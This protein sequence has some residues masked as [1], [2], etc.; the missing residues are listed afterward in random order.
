M[1]DSERKTAIAVTLAVLAL[2]VCCGLHLLVG[3]G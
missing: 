1:P 2:A 3:G